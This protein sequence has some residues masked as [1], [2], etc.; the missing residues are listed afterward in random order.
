MSLTVAEIPR[1]QIQANAAQP[2]KT[3]EGIEDL[4]SSI[5]ANGLLQPIT[6]RPVAAEKFQIV[7]GEQ[8]REV[9][10]L[11]SRQRADEHHAW[12]GRYRHV[13]FWTAGLESN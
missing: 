3:F 8:R 5:A 9:A 11:V 2:R 10:A 13:C 7:A 4:A 1:E 6:V 12:D